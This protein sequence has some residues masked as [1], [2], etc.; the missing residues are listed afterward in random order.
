MH[1]QVLVGMSGEKAL[2]GG[3]CGRPGAARPEELKWPHVSSQWE[4]G[5]KV[6]AAGLV[7]A[8]QRQAEVYPTPAVRPS[9]AALRH[10][11]RRE[12]PHH[13]ANK[14]LCERT[15]GLLEGPGAPMHL[16]LGAGASKGHMSYRMGAIPLN[17]GQRLRILQ[18]SFRVTHLPLLQPRPKCQKQGSTCHEALQTQGHSD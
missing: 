6:D 1:R 18:C 2:K 7:Q 11:Q 15:W 4:I 5:H 12:D 14:H 16:L 13:C 3:G 17:K 10:A 9:G 8:A